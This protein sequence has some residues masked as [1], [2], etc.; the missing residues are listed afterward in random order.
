MKYHLIRIYVIYQFTFAFLPL[1][2]TYFYTSFPFT[3]LDST[4]C[5]GALAAGATIP[6]LF[7]FTELGR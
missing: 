1:P 7:R 4:C 2:F 6:E 5:C 3:A